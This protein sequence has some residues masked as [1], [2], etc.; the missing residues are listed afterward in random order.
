MEVKIMPNMPI[1]TPYL[2]PIDINLL[3]RSISNLIK[4]LVGLL[5]I[6][7]PLIVLIL[8]VLLMYKINLNL[9]RIYRSLNKNANEDNFDAKVKNLKGVFESTEEKNKTDKKNDNNH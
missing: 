8:I 1:S 5:I 7:I 2:Y 4:T 6:I 3:M 9:E